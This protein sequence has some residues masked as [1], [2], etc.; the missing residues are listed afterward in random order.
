MEAYSPCRKSWAG[1]GALFGIKGATVMA[2]LS[3]SRP[4]PALH[5]PRPYRCL[6]LGDVIDLQVQVFD[7]HLH[8][9]PSF[10]GRCTRE[11]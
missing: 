2:P 9:F 3:L 1:E 6:G 4:N 8:R 5:T 7:F 11:L 10:H